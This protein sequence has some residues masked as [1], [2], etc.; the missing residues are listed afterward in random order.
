MGESENRVPWYV[1]IPVLG[2]FLYL[3]QST[4]DFP[5][6][7]IGERLLSIFENTILYSMLGLTANFAGIPED[8]WIMITAVIVIVVTPAEF[9][10]IKR[11]GLKALGWHRIQKFGRRRLVLSIIYVGIQLW[12]FMVLGYFVAEFVLRFLSSP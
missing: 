8:I 6:L 1:F 12:S 11:W 4:K 2:Y 9:W 3:P 7:N 10:L 5:D